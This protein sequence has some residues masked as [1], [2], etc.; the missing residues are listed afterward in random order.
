M[1]FSTYPD[2]MAHL[3]TF[4]GEESCMVVAKNAFP[5][6]ALL[7]QTLRRSVGGHEIPV[8]AL[9]QLVIHDQHQ[10]QGLF[11]HLLDLLE[12]TGQPVFVDDIISPHVERVLRRRGYKDC[13]YR[14]RDTRI[15]ARC[16]QK[17]TR[18]G[19]K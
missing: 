17:G 19:L 6:E 10:R 3:E 4:S 18:L 9:R 1:F 5:V 2:L 16:K 8:L 7:I 13:S 15:F 11:S 12:A 14:K